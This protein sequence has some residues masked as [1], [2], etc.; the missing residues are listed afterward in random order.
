M[1]LPPST[2]PL[3]RAY[4]SGI[5]ILFLDT[6]TDLQKE[7]FEAYTTARREV[8]VLTDCETFMYAFRPG[9]KIMTDVLVEGQMKEICYKLYDSVGSR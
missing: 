1:G 3:R 6:L 7:Q 9:A 2:L 8:N 5:L 4:R